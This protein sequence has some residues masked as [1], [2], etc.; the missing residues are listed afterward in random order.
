MS[1]VTIEDSDASG[2]LLYE[3]ADVWQTTNAGSDTSDTF[4]LAKEANANVTLT[5]TG[6]EVS[7][8]GALSQGTQ[9]AYMFDGSAVTFAPANPG[10]TTLLQLSSQT[11][12]EHTLKLITQPDQHLAV[13]NFVFVSCA[14]STTPTETTPSVTPDASATGDNSAVAPSASTMT[15]NAMAP[16]SSPLASPIP[17]SL[18]AKSHNNTGVIAG[19]TIAVLVIVALLA[20]GIFFW[21]RRR[22]M[23]CCGW[24]K[25]HTAPSAAYLTGEKRMNHSPASS[26]G[27]GRG[28]TEST[29]NLTVKSEPVIRYIGDVKVYD[30][31]YDF[32]NSGPGPGTTGSFLNLK[33]SSTAGAARNLRIDTAIPWRS[34][35]GSVV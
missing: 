30:G 2:A 20:A 25:R 4:H 13:D 19:V 32:A 5:F 17:V 28:Y 34:P 33:K 6:T 31:G 16:G 3:P 14:P 18:A 26:F 7:V 15:T 27:G 1:T 23:S 10:H 22:G 24:R 8:K 12:A 35:G 29:T 11:C 9:V 21:M